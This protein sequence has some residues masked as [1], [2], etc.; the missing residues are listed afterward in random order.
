MRYHTVRRDPWLRCVHGYRPKQVPVTE[1][2]MTR[3][4]YKKGIFILFLIHSEVE[5]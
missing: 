4:I 3:V 5:L 2:T 1:Q